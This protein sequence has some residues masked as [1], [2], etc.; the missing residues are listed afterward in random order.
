VLR[1]GEGVAL[2]DK[3]DDAQ[4]LEITN[5]SGEFFVTSSDKELPD[6]RA[7]GFI[8]T[9]G[10]YFKFRGTDQYWLKAGSNSPENIL[11]Y[12]EFDGSYRHPGKDKA[13]G[14][15]SSGETLHRFAP[16]LK[17]WRLGDPTWANG[18]GKALIGAYNYLAAKG[19]N[20]N[21]FLT[22]NING[23]GKDVWPF[24]SHEDF[25]RFDVSKLEQWNS[26]FDHMQSKGILLHVTIQETENERLFDDGDT[27]PQR[28]LYL[29]ELIARFAHHPG[30]IWNLG[31]ENGPAAHLPVGQNDD[32]RRQMSNY[33]AKA[34]PYDHPVLLHTH[35][36]PG[37]KEE[38]VAPQLGH[39][40][41]DGLSFQVEKRPMVNGEIQLWREKSKAA[42]NEWL[43]TMDEIGIWKHGAIP[44]SKDPNHDRLRHWVLWG[45]LLGGGAG[46]EWYFGAKH[47]STDLSTEDWRTRDRLWE[48]TNHARRF[49]TDHLPYWEMT[50]NNELI[51]QQ[52][53]SAPAPQDH[54]SDS[55]IE[56]DE[57]ISDV[58]QKRAYAFAKEGEIYAAYL[59]NTNGAMLDLSQAQGEFSLHWFDPVNGGELQTGSVTTLTAG[60][61]VS[62]GKAPVSTA[63][64]WVILV[65][66]I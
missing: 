35:S 12:H 17:D 58:G 4:T 57:L 13:S 15:A 29:N 45:S 18:K 36:T 34:D 24:V 14:E 31:E 21:Y 32:Q 37:G 54:H 25:T 6:F 11:A 23:D 20:A 16:H 51:S 44:D 63:M 33:F 55:S 52:G 27:G 49:F 39:L 64:D 10:P 61:A 19:M 8:T 41:L 2:A 26:V 50:A 48:I 62:L 42:G 30:L 43:I 1:K 53:D 9:D 47:D 66:A 5:A 59:S 7:H 3:F 60:S 38:I 40:P 28:Q 56:S 22:L 65:R 46:V